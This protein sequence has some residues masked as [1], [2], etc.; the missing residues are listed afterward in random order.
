MDPELKEAYAELREKHRAL[1]EML[2]VAEYACSTHH[3]NDRYYL[4]EDMVAAKL[5]W[6]NAFDNVDQI[7]NGRPLDP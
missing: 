3:I 5:A 2:E 7:I 6:I 1:L 4:Y